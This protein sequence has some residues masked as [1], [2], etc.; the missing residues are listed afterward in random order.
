MT[1][2]HRARRDS[3]LRT[4][5]LPFLGWPG[6]AVLLYALVRLAGVVGILLTAAPTDVDVLDSL[7]R[8]D[9][10]SYVDIAR[11]GYDWSQERRPDGTLRNTNVAFFPLYPGL[12]AAVAQVSGLSYPVAGLLVSGTAGLVAAV[13]VGGIARTWLGARATLPAV[14]LWAAAPHSVVYGMAYSETLF[15]AL[16]AWC[17]LL[18]LRERWLWAGVFAALAG[19]TRPTASAVVATVGIAALVAMWRARKVLWRPVV[20]GILAVAG[21]LLHPVHCAI[22]LGQW[23]AWLVQQRE[24]WRSTYDF[25]ASE[26]ELLRDGLSVTTTL[27]DIDSTLTLLAGALLAVVLVLERARLPLV[28]Y[29]VTLVA[30][31]WG[32]GGYHQS[33]PRFLLPAFPL[34]LVLVRGLA[35]LRTSSI[36]VLLAAVVSLA[37][38]YGG[39]LLVLQDLSP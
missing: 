11:E 36:V 2:Q 20:A 37:S 28:V 32:T 23:D 18:L 15:I 27:R 19:T 31:A 26:I 4:A 13:A 21:F 14:V 25:G 38:W 1:G 29:S 3:R 5:L 33:K 39:Y 16:A 7:W 24:G 17:L 12:M 8:W 9:G 10:R 35:G 22:R 34:A 6:Q 30:V